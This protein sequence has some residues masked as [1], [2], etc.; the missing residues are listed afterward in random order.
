MRAILY[1]NGR[2]TVRKAAK[3][4]EVYRDDVTAAVRCAIIG[5]EGNEGLARA[6]AEADKRATREAT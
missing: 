5:Y 3:G 6:I 2:Y 4:Y 1:A